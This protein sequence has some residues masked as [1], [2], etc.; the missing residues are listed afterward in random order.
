MVENAA[1]GRPPSMSRE[2]SFAPPSLAIAAGLA[3]ACGGL[4]FLS[5]PGLDIWPLVVVALVPLRI[6]L[7]GQTP[8]RA[9]WIGWLS[10][11]VMSSLGFYWMVEMLRKFSGFPTLICGFFALVVNAFQAGRMGAFGWLF[12]R[13]ERGGWPRG[14]V[15]LA[16]LA[17]TELAF[18]VLFWWSFGAVLHPVPALTQVADLGGVTAVGLVAGAGNWA[19]AEWLLALL[20]G[21]RVPFLTT[22]P[23][24][25]TP[26]LAGVYG[27]SRISQVDHQVA[28]APHSEVGLVQGN[29]SLKGKRDDPTES[30]A[31]HLRGTAQLVNQVHP[32]LVL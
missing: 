10:G 13:A 21:R 32:E 16:A 20:V 27:A 3:V 11:F 22:A 28:A 17:S 26:L 15:W 9:F 23:F 31:R 24:W 19:I 29:M 14:L 12:A 18:P 1:P 4:Y 7:V 25:L 6:A 5:F 30:L 2:R 8:K